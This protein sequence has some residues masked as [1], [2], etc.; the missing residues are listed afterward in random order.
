MKINFK[1]INKKVCQKKKKKDILYKATDR[2]V[3]NNRLK[4][5]DHKNTVR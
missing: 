1:Q 4:T 3:L 5:N 2:I